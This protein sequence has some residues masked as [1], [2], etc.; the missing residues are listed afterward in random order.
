MRTPDG[1]R[2]SHSRLV[3]AM[4]SAETSHIATWQPS[5][6]SCSARARPIPVPPPVMTAIL[7]RKS[8]IVSSA[9]ADRARRLAPYGFGGMRR[10][11]PG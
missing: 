5:A 9:R 3:S 11:C 4:F 2:A 7:P 6:E 1:A 8:F 10:T